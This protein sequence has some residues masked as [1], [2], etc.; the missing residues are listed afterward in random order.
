LWAK[1]RITCAAVL[2]TF[3]KP[4]STAWEFSIPQPMPR[5]NAHQPERIKMAI[6]ILSG[7]LD[8]FEGD[9]ILRGVI[10]PESLSALQVADYQREV[11]PISSIRELAKAIKDKVGVPDI[12][13]GMRGGAYQERMGVFSLSD[14]VFIVD[15]LQRTS[16]AL[17]LMRSGEVPRLGAMVHFNTT[18]EIERTRFRAL[19]MERTSLSPNVL[20][21]NERHDNPVVNMLYLMSLESTFAM[22]NRICWQQRMRRTH[23]IP[24]T[25]FVRTT[26]SLHARFGVVDSDAHSITSAGKL[27]KIKLNRSQIR[28]NVKLFWQTI[29][30]MYGVSRITYRELT[31]FLRSTFLSTLCQVYSRHDDFW[32]DGAFKLNA[33]LKR[34]IASFPLN[35][36]GVQQLC[37]AGNSSASRILFPMLV[38]HINSG[39]R[40]RRLRVAKEVLV[41][42]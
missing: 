36:P 20:L 34:K 17:E 12:Q 6:K 39:K 5:G 25:T 27:M 38:E 19:N 3:N 37:S 11:L 31:P 35:D 40:T 7:A 32:D 14:E 23:L 16:A 28:T 30:D 41:E 21:Y 15:G 22:Q 4:F 10:A 42:V 29:E 24:A 33:D 1:C 9:I 26:V 8:E 18:E 2:A 13:L